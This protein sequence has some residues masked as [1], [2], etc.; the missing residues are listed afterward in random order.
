MKNTAFYFLMAL[1]FGQILQAQVNTPGEKSLIK[2][3]P[4]SLKQVDKNGNKVYRDGNLAKITENKKTKEIEVEITELILR[5]NPK[6]NNELDKQY[7]NFIN[8]RLVNVYPYFLEALKEYNAVTLEVSK[9]PENERKAYTKKRYNELAD[10][11]EEKL[12]ALT[13]SEGKIFCKLMSRATDKTVYGIIK[14]L[15]GGWSAML[16]S[17]TADFADIDIDAPYSPYRYRDDE[18]TEVLLQQSW[19]SGRLK[20]YDGALDYK[21]KR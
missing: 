3:I 21:E 4:D 10:Q 1:G 15:R 12:K 19:A 5:G 9:I 13:T 17:F 14:E 2:Q 6:F 20:P 7:F 8:K 16:W 18:F 11:Y